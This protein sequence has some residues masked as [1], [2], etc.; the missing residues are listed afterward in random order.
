MKSGYLIGLDDD[1][2]IETITDEAGCLNCD[3]D[4]LSVSIGSNHMSVTGSIGRVR[5]IVTH[6][7]VEPTDSTMTTEVIESAYKK[8]CITCGGLRYCATR[9][10]MHTPCGWLCG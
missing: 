8:R 10:C 2:T 6:E 9:G 7:V 4:D 5:S 1:T 3:I